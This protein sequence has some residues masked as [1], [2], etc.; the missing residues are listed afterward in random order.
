MPKYKS[1]LKENL[2]KLRRD[3]GMTQPDLA[4][5]ANRYWPGITRSAIAAIETRDILHTT[6]DVFRAI[7]IA[8]ALDV[9]VED[10]VL[11]ENIT[12]HKVSEDK[13]GYPLTTEKPEQIIIPFYKEVSGSMGDGTLAPSDESQI[14]NFE[15]NKRFINDLPSNTGVHNL[16]IIL[17]QGYSMVP[18]FGHGDLLVVDAG[19]KTAEFDGV[20]FFRIAD[21]FY[22]KILELM[23]TGIR[24]I[25]KNIDY[26]TWTIS[27]DDD[28]EVLARVLRAWEA[29]DPV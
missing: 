25:S 8:K 22:I 2:N 4:A 11:S 3:R 10:L 9:S 16:K 29:K 14:V 28:F 17:G 24:A 1:Y 19:V 13:A 23:P 6:T 26:S 5:A 21:Q 27:P 15:V 18:M 12:L 20:Y 7:A